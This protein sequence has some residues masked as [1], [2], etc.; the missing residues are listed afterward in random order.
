LNWGSA[1]ALTIG[2]VNRTADSLGAGY[3]DHELDAASIAEVRVK[4]AM[5]A[6]GAAVAI[7]GVVATAFSGVVDRVDYDPAPDQ[8]CWVVRCTDNLQGYFEA[9]GAASVAAGNHVSVGVVAALPAG[10]YWHAALFT[11]ASDGWEACQ[12]AMGCVASSIWLAGGLLQSASWQPGASAR[13]IAHAA[14]GI[15]DGSVRID[16]AGVRD[17]VNQVVLA[18]DIQYTRLHQWRLDVGWPGPG[19]DFCDNYANAI[20]WP[21]RNLIAEAVGGNSWSLLAN[22]SLLSGVGNGIFGTRLWPS[23]DYVCGTDV[24]V[25]INRDDADNHLMG[26]SWRMGRRWSQGIREKYTITVT[27]TGAAGDGMNDML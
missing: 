4:G 13:T 15:Y 5:P 19:I 18:V 8:R 17:L 27:G 14:G 21:S 7:S 23:G 9:L 12:D 1:Y 16:V 3:V 20:G 11:D 6:V 26:A 22:G 10:A 24:V 25:W 2:G